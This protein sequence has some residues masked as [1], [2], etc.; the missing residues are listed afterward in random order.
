MRPYN[1]VLR[2]LFSILFLTPSGW[3]QLILRGANIIAAEYF[4]GTDPGVGNGTSVTITSP[5]QSVNLE[6]SSL[7]LPLNQTVFIRCRDANNKWSA[8]TPYRFK[9]LGNSR[10]VDITRAEYFIGSD[11]GPGNGAAI[12]VTAGPNPGLEALKIALS[13]GQRLSTRV[14]DADGRWSGAVTYTFKGFGNNRTVDITKAEYFIGSDPGP[15]NG[16]AISL[17]S[18]LN[19]ISEAVNVALSRGQRISTRVRDADGRWSNPVASAYPNEIVVRAE[20]YTPRPVAPGSGTPMKAT[21]G[22]FNS[23]VE[24][25]E[26]TLSNWNR[27]DSIWVRVQSSTYFWSFPVGDVIVSRQNPSVAEV[28][29]Q[30]MLLGD[31]YKI[32]SDV[33]MAIISR[34]SSK[35]QQFDDNGTPIVGPTGDIGIMQINPNT[36]AIQMNLDSVRYSWRYN[37]ETGCRILKDTKFD[38]YAVNTASPYDTENDTDPSIIE[39]WYYPIAWY[40][41]SG[42]AAYAYV[43]T[44]WGYLSSPPPIASPH[45]PGVQS[46]GNPRSLPGFPATI[47]DKIPY[48]PQPGGWWATAT[49]SDLYSHGVYTLLLLARNGERIHRWDWKTST[50]IDITAQILTGVLSQDLE[51]PRE[52]SL[53][54]NYPNPFNPSTTIEFALPKSAFVTLRVYDVLGRQVGELVNEKLAPGNYKTQWNASGL[55][56]GVYFYRLQAGEFVQTRKLL[57]L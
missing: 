16:T 50:I 55:A 42:D 12:S 43:G 20:L 24:T 34:E 49:P 48:P 5:G 2:L 35:W 28:V 21:D 56:S 18:G 57:L 46:I 53:S 41:G 15:G 47:Y 23:A 4:V 8:A 19:P 33:I 38:L 10:S 6:R 11:P 26:G 14:R 54:Q 32:P 52:F 51:I 25:V 22:S 31:K 45:F 29:A 36:P 9:G 3:A 1:Y 13:T 39:N 27:T 44:V 17:T 40:N 30:T 7:N 37:M